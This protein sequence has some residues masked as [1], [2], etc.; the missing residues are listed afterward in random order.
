M[1]IPLT[2][3]C[4]IFISV[5]A[6]S[7]SPPTDLATSEG[8][9]LADNG[10]DPGPAPKG[11]FTQ[12][13]TCNN[14]T[15]GPAHVVSNGG[16]MTGGITFLVPVFWGPNVAQDTVSKSPSFLNLLA[17]SPW[18]RGIEAE[19]IGP[20]QVKVW[21][22]SGIVITPQQS[23]G[24]VVNRNQIKTELQYQIQQNTLPSATY[25]FLYVVYFP[26]SVQVVDNGSP[27][28]PA[29]PGECAYHDT[30]GGTNSTFAVMAD[31]TVQCANSCATG[32]TNSY[33]GMT[34][35]ESHEIAEA[36]TDPDYDNDGS[37]SGF[38]LRTV[39]PGGQCT[40]SAE[41]G[42]IC[43][44]NAAVQITSKPG[45][46]NPTS[47]WIQPIWSNRASGCVTAPG[48]RGDVDG[49]GYSDLMLTGGKNWASMPV[50][51]ANGTAGD[52]SWTGT[53]AGIDQGDTGFPTYATQPGAIPVAGDFNGDGHADIALVGGVGWNTIPVAFTDPSHPGQYRGTN[54]TDGGFSAFYQ[55]GFVPVSGDFNG[56][57]YA[58]IALVGPTNWQSI[59]IALSNGDGTFQYSNGSDGGLA[60]YYVSGFRPIAGDFNCDG[61]T[62]IALIG[63]S[64]WTNIPVAFSTGDEN[65]DFT[66]SV[67]PDGGFH[68]YYQ[69]GFIA[70]AVSGLCGDSIALVGVPTWTGLPMAIPM[71]NNSGFL[72]AFRASYSDD[73]GFHTFYKPGIQ[74]VPGDYNGDGMGDIALTGVS[75][76]QSMPIAYQNKFAFGT[77]DYSYTTANKGETAGDTGFPVYASQSGAQVVIPTPRP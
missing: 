55:P 50:A 22:G 76:W 17:S 24:S 46:K 71:F 19:Y 63:V 10:G 53:N 26:S 59:P 20:Q 60:Q 31:H 64:S 58:D 43:S 16:R 15:P 8:Q 32:V 68:N 34:V 36:L 40:L 48:V 57:G 49:D 70:T 54:K 74:A 23:T 9:G 42:D 75:G 30:L 11:A 12:A 66:L 56:D 29:G 27:L 51:F 65:G 39:P 14:N 3:L 52:G 1:K 28:C 45:T 44:G 47:A 13:S 25:A 67:L 41:I 37:P 6:C 7:S 2:A 18:M 69:P 33:D 5:A 62:D 35:M 72:N 21:S 61:L 38:Q 4:S 77:T 73:G